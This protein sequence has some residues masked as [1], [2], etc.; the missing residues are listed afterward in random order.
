[1]L[2]HFSLSWPPQAS[3]SSLLAPLNLSERTFIDFFGFSE[4]QSPS[5]TSKINEKPLVFLGFLLFSHIAQDG[6]KSYQKATE[7]LP[8]N[9]LTCQILSKILPK[10]LKI[11]PRHLQNAPPGLPDDPR[12]IPGRTKTTPDTA[13]LSNIPAR[14]LQSSIFERP[15]GRKLRFSLDF[16]KLASHSALQASKHPRWGRRNAR[17]VPPPH[18]GGRRV[19]D[20]KSAVLA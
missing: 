1:M 8:G 5:R 19:L 12:H 20:S 13:K 17:S 11:V 15:G 18:R 2:A 10:R 16:S 14:P 6:K 7:S 9:A 4:P 3:L